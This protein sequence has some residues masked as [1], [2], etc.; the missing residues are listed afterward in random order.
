MLVRILHMG[1]M[2]KFGL[3]QTLGTVFDRGAQVD[4]AAPPRYLIVSARRLPTAV[5]CHRYFIV[6][7]K[8]LP[9]APFLVH[10]R[11]LMVVP[12]PLPAA[13]LAV[14]RT[15]LIVMLRPVF[16]PFPA[17]TQCCRI[18]KRTLGR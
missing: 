14:S 13:P 12:R 4:S 6:V 1:T 18:K 11:Y 3:A 9:A 7:P 8:L 10:R 16:R 15:Y 17:A 2:R 5:V